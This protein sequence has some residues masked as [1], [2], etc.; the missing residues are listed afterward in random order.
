[1]RRSIGIALVDQAVLSLF[2][3]GLNLVLIR[4]AA[5][6]EFGRFVFASAVLLLLTSLQNA[7]VATPLAVLLPGRPAAEQTATAT[8][9]VSADV[10]FRWLAAAVA[11]LLCLL[12]NHSAD[13]LAAVALAAFAGLA[14]ETARN[15]ALA[16]ER[17]SECLR[18]DTVAMVASIAAT[19]ALW[20][21][22][23][24]AVACLTGMAIGSTIALLTQVTTRIPHYQSLAVAMRAYRGRYWPDTQWSLIGAATTELQYRSYVFAVDLFRG[25]AALAL[26][27]AGRLL[28]GPLPL[29]VGAWGRVARPA[30]ARHLAAGDPGTMLKLTA[31]GMAYVLSVG[32][33]YC[34]FLYLVW[35]YIEA[36]VFQGKYPGVANLTL[37]WGG[38][39][40]TVIAHMVLSIPLQA[41]MWLKQLA[42]VTMVTAILS[43][44]LLLGLATSVPPIYAVLALVGAEMFSLVWHLLLVARL[45]RQSGIATQQPAMAPQ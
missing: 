18:I 3:L 39:F 42:Q 21:V 5:P 30:M 29:V 34:L 31:Q 26:V 1:L 40:F 8:T 23:S 25:A 17:T 22:V 41:A 20:F 35:P 33:A 16:Y 27:Q 43:Y 38:Y 32:A 10:A 13:F 44:L 14:R 12:T 4:L 28:L 2:N 6:P 36:S 19:A 37:A 9:I 45:A 7:L 24:P 15:L 11:P